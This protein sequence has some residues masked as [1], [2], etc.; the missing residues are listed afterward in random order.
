MSRS[1]S[2]GR[3]RN[4]RGRNRSRRCW[5]RRRRRGSGSGG[6]RIS[7]DY[8]IHSSNRCSRRCRRCGINGGGGGGGDGGGGVAIIIIISSSFNSSSRI[9][10]SSRS[11]NLCGI[12]RIGGSI[13]MG[14]ICRLGGRINIRCVNVTINMIIINSVCT[15]TTWVVCC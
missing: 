9:I 1:R 7:S 4:G 15:N 13:R 3:S 11:R 12:R 8:N 10:I 14:A 2:R 5:C 6:G